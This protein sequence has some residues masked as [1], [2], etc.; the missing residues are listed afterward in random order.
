MLYETEAE[1]RHGERDDLVENIFLFADE[2]WD[3]DSET[4][5]VTENSDERNSIIV[6][7]L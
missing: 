3:N 1:I 2:E 7:C 6:S 4:H 5:D